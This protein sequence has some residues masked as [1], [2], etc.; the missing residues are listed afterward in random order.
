MA[1]LERDMVKPQD[2]K[3]VIA[4]VASNPEGRLLAW[5]HLRA[6]WNSLQALF[7]NGTFTMGS[8]ISAVTAHFAADYDYK[9]VMIFFFASLTVNFF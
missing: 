8:L 4:T 6:H 2:V 9:E 7:G 1:T 3:L 5:R